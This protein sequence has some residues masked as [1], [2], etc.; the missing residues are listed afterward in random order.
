MPSTPGVVNF[1]TS[2]DDAASLLEVADLL[3]TTLAG[4]IGTSDNITLSLASATGWP[5]T[6]VFQLV[7]SL[8]APTKREILRYTAKS[9]NDLTI[10]TGG[11]GLYGTT[12]QSWSGTVYAVMRYQAIHHS[13]PRDAIIAVQTKL[14]IGAGAPVSGQFLKGGSGG[15]SAWAALAIADVANLQ[16]TLDGKQAAFANQNANLVYAGPSSGGAAAPSFRALVAGDI[17]DLSGTYAAV[18]HN[19]DATY[20]PLD[21]DLAAIAALSANGLLRKTAGVW[22]MDSASYLTGNQT[23]TLSGDLSGSGATSIAA[24]IAN[25]AVTL[26][27]MA[28]LAA[29]SI[30]GNNTGSGATPAALTPSQ[31]LDIIGSTRGAVL[32]RGASGW[33]VLT[34]GT[35]GHFL[36]TS[37]TGADPVWAAASASVDQ[38]AAYTWTGAHIWTGN[39]QT[40]KRNSI[41][42]TSATGLELTNE[43]AAAAGA[44]QYSA[45]LVFTGQGWKTAATAASQPVNFRLELQPVQGT[46]NPSANFVFASQVNGGGYTTRV[47]ITSAGEL[48][49]ASAGSFTNP[50]IS[51]NSTAAGFYID[52]NSMVFKTGNGIQAAALH[53]GGNGGLLVPNTGVIGFSSSNLFTLTPDTGMTRAAAGII[54]INNGTTGTRRWF[55]WQGVTRVTSNTNATTTTLADVGGTSQA[56]LSGRTYS[57]VFEANFDADATGGYK[58]AIAYSGTSSAIEYYVEVIRDD[59]GAVTISSRQTSSGGA[60]GAAGG[61]SGR[62]RIR[63]SITTTGTGNLTAQFAQNAANGTSTL[64]A[65]GSRLVTFDIP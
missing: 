36:Q 20:Q 47:T 62:V 25:G 13:A 34:P 58:F 5:L 16:T 11:R 29:N 15:A 6:G 8:T 2:L 41:G 45:G 4:S 46:S 27:K 9:G 22:G 57:F 28:N 26:A 19:H 39:A 31:V 10:P 61:T 60:A 3:S 35:S 33:A 37:G 51:L 38:A 48:V 59:T 44:Q 54:E 21:A 50:A 18:G 63:G 65:A 1:P 7:D 24:T 40:I 32:Y 12:A 30:I 42:T 49:V 64:R 17:P 43:T 23:I 14:G 56:L 52:S 55:T 53:N